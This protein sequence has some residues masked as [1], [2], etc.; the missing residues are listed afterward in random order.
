MTYIG[1]FV[2]EMQHR[3]TTH[4]EEVRTLQDSVTT[5]LRAETKR[6][7]DMHGGCLMGS[8]PF[9]LLLIIQSYVLLY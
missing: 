5:Q 1:K 4:A 2:F 3:E 6:Y 9:S 8:V 7:D